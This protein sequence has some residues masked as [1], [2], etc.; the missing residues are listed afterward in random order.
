MPIINIEDIWHSYYKGTPLETPSLTGLS[1]DVPKGQ[2]VALIG[3]TGSGKSTLL[4]HLNGLL[5]PDRGRVLIDSLDTKD[6]KVRKKLWRRVGLLM[7]YPEK[8]FF[9]ETIYREVSFGPKNTGLSAPEIDQRVAEALAMVGINADAVKGLSP[10]RLSGG[11]QRRVALASVLAFNPEILALDEPTAGI[12]PAGREKIILSLKK[13]KDKHG[14][15]I[16]LASHNMDDVAVLADR[17]VVMQEGK[18]I[19][20]GETRQVFSNTGLIKKAGLDLP[21]PCEIIDRLNE[22]GFGIDNMPLSLNEA[23]RQIFW[24]Y[25]KKKSGVE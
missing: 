14:K 17:V 21:L 7:Q 8:Q 20:S 1:L 5:L 9:E 18:L 23:A 11:E 12:D 16:I 3:P 19:L 24:S 25:N 4:K 13:L 15:T 2:S 6:K 10:F 22:V